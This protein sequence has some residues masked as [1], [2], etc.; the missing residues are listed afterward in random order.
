MQ[1]ANLGTASVA[2][3]EERAKRVSKLKAP[4]FGSG[5]KPKAAPVFCYKVHKVYGQ[6]D[7]D[8]AKLI[9]LMRNSRCIFKIW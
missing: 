9:A 3:Q 8:P 2:E 1:T 4:T 6:R 5:G 7:F